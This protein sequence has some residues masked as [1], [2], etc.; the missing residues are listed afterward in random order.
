MKRARFAGVRHETFEQQELV[1]R[2]RD[3]R[4]LFCAVPNGAR[5]KPWI[6]NQL[7]A[8]GMESGVPDILIFDRPSSFKIP[9][10]VPM[11]CGVAVE[12]KRAKG[13]TVS[14]SQKAWHES[15]RACGWYVIVARGAADA[16]T[17]LTELGY[18]GLPVPHEVQ[19]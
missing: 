11:P 19:P 8:E 6:A 2:L 14:K 3:A 13:G 15:L 12:M 17:Q 18:R 1:R 4:I 7:K 16:L 5:V 10:E 9:W